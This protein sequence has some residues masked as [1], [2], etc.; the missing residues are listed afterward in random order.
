[1]NEALDTMTVRRAIYGR[2]SV[3]EYSPEI[4]DQPTLHSLLAAAVRAPTAMHG[5]PWQFVVIQDPAKLKRLSDLA[6]VTIAAESSR[7]H[8][9]HKA[10]GLFSQPG[11]NVFYG[12]STLVVICAATTGRFEQA[13]CWLAA[14]N[15][16][17]AAHSMGLG[18]CVI[19]LAAAALNT[20]QWKAELKIPAEMTAYAPIIVGV[21]AGE[22]PATGRQEPVVLAWKTG[23]AT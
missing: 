16:M 8:P 4:I 2:C 21:P 1:M 10:P 12:A 3:R 11:F 23:L 5:E 22:T 18:T 20:P 13:D 9:D 19:G 7:L 6:K 17:L 15:L 14:E